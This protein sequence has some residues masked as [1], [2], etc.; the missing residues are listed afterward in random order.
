[1]IIKIFFS[2][3]F[4]ISVDIVNKV[5]ETQPAR[6]KLI[7]SSL[8]C[9]IPAIDIEGADTDAFVNQVIKLP[10]DW[11]APSRVNG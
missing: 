11:P 10:P 1:M 6:M 7:T 3:D 2:N 9:D 5:V 8:T 4:K